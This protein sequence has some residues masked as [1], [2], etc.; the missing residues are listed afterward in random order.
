MWCL[1]LFASPKG[2]ERPVS[3]VV[4]TKALGSYKYDGSQ[5]RAGLGLTPGVFRAG[6]GR[7]AG[8]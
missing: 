1:G 6:A 2:P 5:L 7:G 4:R 3:G 8:A